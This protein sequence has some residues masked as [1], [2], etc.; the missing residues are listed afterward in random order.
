M[1]QAETSHSSGNQKTCQ[2]TSL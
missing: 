1:V 2:R